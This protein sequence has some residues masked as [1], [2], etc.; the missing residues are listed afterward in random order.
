VL[1]LSRT[2]ELL[3]KR[4]YWPIFLALFS[5]HFASEFNAMMRLAMLQPSRILSQ[6]FSLCF[7]H[8]QRVAKIPCD[9]TATRPPC[10]CLLS[11]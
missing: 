10:C 9:M 1:F 2:S 8:L 6:T 4:R 5:R 11:W 7:K 3:G